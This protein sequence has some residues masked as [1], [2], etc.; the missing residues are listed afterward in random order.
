MDGG[1]SVSL[2]SSSFSP[3]H[4]GP[5]GPSASAGHPSCASVRNVADGLCRDDLPVTRKILAQEMPKSRRSSLARSAARGGL[6]INRA[7]ILID[8]IGNVRL[9]RRASGGRGGTDGNGAF[10][11]LRP[12]L[13]ST[14]RSLRTWRKSRNGNGAVECVQSQR[15]GRS[16]V[17]WGS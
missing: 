16:T 12:S 3:S 6:Q 11:T 5:Y 9:Y 2:M 10:N 8:E 1:L 15:A 7:N 17:F 4:I 14:T 13:N